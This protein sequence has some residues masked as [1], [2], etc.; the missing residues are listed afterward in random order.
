MST[1]QHNAVFQAG[2]A[3]MAV[4]VAAQDLDG[5]LAHHDEDLVFINGGNV[6]DKPGL[7]DYVRNLW[8]EQPDFTVELAA[9]YACDDVLVVTLTR[10]RASR[11]GMARSSGCTGR[12]SSSTR[13]TPPR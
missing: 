5:L 2:L 11:R 7:A 1:S 3:E 6:M 10:P 13:S 12:S 8:A 9:S 4:A